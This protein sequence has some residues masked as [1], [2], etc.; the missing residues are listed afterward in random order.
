MESN[1]DKSQEWWNSLSDLEKCDAYY[2]YSGKVFDIDFLERLH[3]LFIE[4]M[5]N[6]QK[7]VS[8]IVDADK[9]RKDYSSV[10]AEIYDKHHVNPFTDLLEHN[11]GIIKA[12]ID[13][14]IF[15]KENS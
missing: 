13:F 12:M 8:V 6:E 11:E 5:Y 9:V 7:N 1:Y 3:V 15:Y 4:E 10:I 2:K 14:A